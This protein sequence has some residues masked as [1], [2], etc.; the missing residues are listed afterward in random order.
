MD[1]TDILNAINRQILNPIIFLLFFLASIYFVWGLIKFLA[2]S[3]SDE[4]RTE[5][6][7]HMVWGI[8]GMIIMVSAYAILALVTRSFGVDMPFES[9]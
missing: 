8:V 6:K 1:I 7:S 9:Q 4:A 3:D 5:G 2:N